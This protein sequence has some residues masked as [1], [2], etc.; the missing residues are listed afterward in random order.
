MSRHGFTDY[1]D[2]EDDP[3]LAMGRWAGRVKSALRGQRGQDFLRR[4]IAALDAM[5]VKELHPNNL[6]GD[7]VCAMGALARAET[8]LTRDLQDELDDPDGDH[9]WATEVMGDRLNI[10]PSLAREVAYENDEGAWDETPAQRWARM[11]CWAAKRLR[12]TP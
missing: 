8:I 2:F 6:A 5:Q 11:R 7:C 12:A 4:L 1:Y 3:N 10:A 9:E